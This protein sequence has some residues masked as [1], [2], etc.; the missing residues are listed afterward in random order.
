MYQSCAA[1]AEPRQV[2]LQRPEQLFPALQHERFTGIVE[3]VSD[4]RVNYIRIDD[5]EFVHALFCD[6]PDNVSVS[7]HMHR[8]F[9]PHDDGTRRA[10]SAAVFPRVDDFPDQASPELIQTYRELFWAIAEQADGETSGSASKHVHHFRDLLKKVHR[11]LEVIGQPLDRETDDL[12]TTRDELTLALSDWA[13]QVLEQVEITAPGAAPSILRDATRE[14]RFVLQS[15]GFY[16][17]LPW[18][19]AW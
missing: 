17:R 10:I 18:T 19:V 11:P 8:L 15:A 7:Q 5:G 4:G 3:L 12:V 2:D 14:Q 9:A 13:L 6:K 16:E 1:P